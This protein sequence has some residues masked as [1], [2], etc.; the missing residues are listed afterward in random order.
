MAGKQVSETRDSWCTSADIIKRLYLFSGPPALD[1]CSNP[2]SIVGA[3]IEWYGPPNGTNGLV[4]PWE[5]D[6]YVFMN[7]PYSAKE[8]WMHKA[9]SEAQAGAE[10]ICLLPAD[11]DT[12][13]F[14]RYAVPA[15]AKCFPRGRI[16]FLGDRQSGAMHASALFYYGERPERFC[17][18]FAEIGWCVLKRDTISIP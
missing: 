8:A 1:P 9:Y 6:G 3:A 17:Q 15:D 16:S 11:T 5:V 14:H 18:I 10:I 2:N 4:M 12:V 13:W 7:P